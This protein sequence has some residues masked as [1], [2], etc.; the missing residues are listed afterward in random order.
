MYYSNT[1]IDGIQADK[2]MALKLDEALTGVR[3]DIISQLKTIE[4][5]AT[6]LTYYASCFTDNYQDVCSRLRFEDRRFLYG[7]LQLINKRRI[8]FDMVRIYVDILLK[9]RSFEQLDSIKR[10]L[11]QLGI[12]IS[13]SYGTNTGLSLAITTAICLSFSM[14]AAVSA[15]IVKYKSA[16]IAI[17][18]AGMY[19]IVQQAADSANHLKYFFPEY[20]NALY[21]AKLEMMYFLIHPI[22]QRGGNI[23]STY[24]LS[25]SEVAHIISR[26]IS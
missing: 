18:A 14:N 21:I 5:G 15:G 4:A 1:I 19:G 23:S 24:H 16:S 20:Y 8:I 12:R 13:V 10:K 26:L 17:T 9:H 2:I 3:D 6:R 22:I 25:D 7:V 11:I